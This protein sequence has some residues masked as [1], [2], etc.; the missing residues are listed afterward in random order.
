MSEL[1]VV[2]VGAGPAGLSAALILGRARKRVLVCDAGPRR[3]A[4]AQ[5]VQGFLTQDG[6]P[7]IEM[8]RIAR[9]QLAQYTSVEHREVG[10]TRIE[11][12]RDHFRVTVGDQVVSSRRVLLATGM[13]DL[14]PAIDGFAALWGKSIYQCPYCH[15]WE[16]RDQAF[17]C[18]VPAIEWIDYP[19][20]LRGWSSDVVMFTGGAF[21][22]PDDVRER[23]TRAGVRIEERAI[24]RVVADASG[25]H[26]E[27]IEVDG[28]V[29]VA[30][31]AFF[32]H[33]KQR[34]TDLVASLGLELDPMGYVKVDE[35]NATSRAGI[36][37]AGDLT[38]MGQSAI[39]AAAAGANAAYRMNH[40]LTVE[41]FGGPAH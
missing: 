14:M 8:R 37:A 4:A 5:H 7:P 39:L 29:R 41:T 20:I 35:S 34:Q 12:E 9:A 23:V 10:I 30:R 15:G 28:G 38:T 11:G 31:S 27:S 19:L 22:I 33:L 36:H 18:I 2:V 3:N 21:S 16:V 6:T 13:V 40:Q 1:D 26:L 24:R 17:G 32:V 25:D